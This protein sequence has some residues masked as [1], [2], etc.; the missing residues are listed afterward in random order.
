MSFF[1]VKPEKPVNLQAHNITTNS[2]D[3][4]WSVPFPLQNFPPGLLHRVEFR[5]EWE[6]EGTWEVGFKL[7]T[8]YL[9]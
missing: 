3:L 7:N 6:P 2:I 1:T 8:L 9:Y 5:S 4:T